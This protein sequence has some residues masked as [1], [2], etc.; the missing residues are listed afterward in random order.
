[1]TARPRTVEKAAVQREIIA[2]L[3][4][5]GD[6]R[7]AD[8]LQ[9]CAEVRLSR[10]HGSGWPETCRNPGCVWCGPATARRWSRGIERWI[11]QDGAPVSLAVLPLHHRPGDLRAAVVRL[12]R[13]IRDVRDRAARRSWRWRGVAAAGMATGDAAALLLIRHAGVERAEVAAVLRRR[14]SA[15]AI[16]EVGAAEPSWSLST[17]DAAELARAR[18]GVEPLRIVIL[19]Q[20]AADTSAGQRAAVRESAEPF[21]PMPIAF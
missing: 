7:A 14:W 11:V 10:R 13:S 3:R 2:A 15:A 6:L 17:A 19:A 5:S 1:M 4:T 21:A 9:R 8:G 12:R 18:R 16:G 20:R